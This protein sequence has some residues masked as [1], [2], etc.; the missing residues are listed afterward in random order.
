MRRW[1]WAC[2]ASAA[3][4]ETQLQ[5]RAGGQQFF[6]DPVAEAIL[7]AK[8]AA[9]S[10]RGS[11]DVFVRDTVNGWEHVGERGNACVSA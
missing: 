4:Q 1:L 9:D 8:V 5:H 10:S 2:H 6:H 3:H 11:R 7:R